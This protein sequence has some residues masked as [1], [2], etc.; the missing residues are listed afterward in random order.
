M[1][2][3]RRENRKAALEQ[4]REYLWPRNPTAKASLFFD[5]ACSALTFLFFLLDLREHASCSLKFLKEIDG[6]ASGARLS[7]VSNKLAS[8]EVE[9]L[10]ETELRL[11]LLGSL[12]PERKEKVGLTLGLQ[13]PKGFAAG[14][15]RGFYDAIDGNGNWVFSRIGG[16]EGETEKGGVLFSQRGVVEE[17]GSRPPAPERRWLGK[18]GGGARAPLSPPLNPP[19]HIYHVLY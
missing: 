8:G 18:L 10:C 9:N 6:A 5:Y 13:L 2:L 3:P 11:G 16:S 1:L 14:A 7:E 19:V 12:L 15:K 4:G 17:L